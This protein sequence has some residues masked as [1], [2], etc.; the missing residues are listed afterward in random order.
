MPLMIVRK[1]ALLAALPILA[2]AAEPVETG[3]PVLPRD[4]LVEIG[5]SEQAFPALE[6]SL[7]RLAAV[8]W[9]DPGASEGILTASPVPAEESLVLKMVLVG[10]PRELPVE[11]GG[12]PRDCRDVYRER[13]KLRAQILRM[14]QLRGSIEWRL[15]RMERRC[16]LS[17]S[18]ATRQIDAELKELNSLIG[19]VRD[20]ADR[21]ADAKP[22]RVL[23]YRIRAEGR[24]AEQ[25][26][27]MGY[28]PLM[29][30]AVGLRAR[31]NGGR[32]L[33][34]PSDGFTVAQGFE[35]LPTS[36][37]K[38]WTLRR[39]LTASQTCLLGLHFDLEF[40]TWWKKTPADSPLIPDDLLMWVPAKLHAPER[41]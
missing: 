31:F 41:W 21:E 40:N 25:L 13:R 10:V 23:E 12:P 6:L 22:D 38:E 2:G 14:K 30:E 39:K 32:W 16:R 7:A 34:L 36:D 20:F 3:V 8:D 15:A 28:S 35:S 26:R 1:I 27:S 5:A 24:V 4:A 19:Q 29:G 9:L 17:S 11:G 18:C 33:E 37:G